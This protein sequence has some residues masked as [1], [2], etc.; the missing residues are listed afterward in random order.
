MLRNNLTEITKNKVGTGLLVE[1]DGYISMTE[2][3]NKEL[4]ESVRRINEGIGDEKHNYC[5]HPFIVHA[6]FQKYGIENAN[7]R[8]YPENVLKKQVAAY[9]K[10][11]QERNAYGE[12]DHPTDRSQVNLKEISMNIIELHWEGQTLVGQLEVITTPGFRNYGIVSTQGDNIANILLNGLKIGVSSRGVGSVENKFGKFIVGDDYEIICWD[13]VGDPS[14]PGAWIDKSK[15]NLTPYLENSEKKGN[16][17][18]ERNSK[19]DKFNNWLRL[20][21]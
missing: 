18:S 12:T 10:K 15:E 21:D 5:P 6:V 13:Y 16:I 14:T 4:L 2:G 17:L 9:Q 1:N 3:K 7:G 11:I 20:N 19:L 8:I